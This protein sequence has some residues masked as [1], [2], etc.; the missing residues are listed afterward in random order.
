MASKKKRIRMRKQ[1]QLM[2]GTHDEEIISSIN[3]YPLK[4]NS[5]QH[6]FD[7]DELVYKTN[8]SVDSGGRA[9]TSALFYELLPAFSSKRLTDLEHLLIIYVHGP[10]E[11][12]YD[13]EK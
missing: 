2:K 8:R 9:N 11:E 5:I 4:M 1:Y 10:Y 7:H 3:E 13:V 12:G 6:N